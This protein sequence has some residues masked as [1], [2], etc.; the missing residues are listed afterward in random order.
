[1]KIATAHQMTKPRLA[2]LIDITWRKKRATGA[3]EVLVSLFRL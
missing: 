1:L 2:G 3:A